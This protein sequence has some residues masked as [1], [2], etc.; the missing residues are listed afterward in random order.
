MVAGA[1]PALVSVPEAAFEVTRFSTCHVVALPAPHDNGV[2]PG[3]SHV[4]EPA[5]GV[6]AN[7]MSGRKWGAQKAHFLLQ[8]MGVQK[9]QMYWQHH[10]SMVPEA[11]RGL[12]H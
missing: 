3:D 5:E 9:Y 6:D 11:V 7:M 10:M 1:R 12:A 2:A 8:E 4:A